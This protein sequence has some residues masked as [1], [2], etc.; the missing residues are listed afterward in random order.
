VVAALLASPYG[1]VL[2][3]VPGGPVRTVLAW[4]LVVGLLGLSVLL[5][6]AHH[7]ANRDD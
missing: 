5:A 3:S 6:V 1:I 4:F 7:Y 2:V